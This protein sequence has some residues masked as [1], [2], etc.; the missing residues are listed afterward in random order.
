VFHP[1]YLANTLQATSLD[2]DSYYDVVFNAGGNTVNGIRYTGDYLAQIHAG[3]LVEMRLSGI[4]GHPVHLHVN[5]FQ[6]SSL[7]SES[8]YMQVGDWHDT[9]LFEASSAPSGSVRFYT[10]VYVGDMVIHCHLATHEVI[11]LNLAVCVS[12]SCA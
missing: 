5:H 6:I 12:L 9:F 8:S 2:I 3:S 4:R 11:A 1:C 7:Q 10:D